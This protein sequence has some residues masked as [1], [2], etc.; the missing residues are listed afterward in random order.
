MYEFSYIMRCL[1]KIESKKLLVKYMDYNRCVWVKINFVK[2]KMWIIYFKTC[3]RKK[4]R[5]FLCNDIW[6]HLIEKEKK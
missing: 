5:S 2:R 4:K 3:L 1:F 6:N